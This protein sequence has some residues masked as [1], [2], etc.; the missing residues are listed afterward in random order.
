M[1][2]IALRFSENFSPDGGTIKAHM[3]IIN[4]N[5]YVWYGKMG[6]RIS[7][8]VRREILKDSCDILLIR[9]GHSE[10]YWAKVIE[11]A[12]CPSEKEFVPEYYREEIDLFHTWFKVVSFTEAPKDIMSKCMVSSSKQLLGI[13]SKHSMSPYFVIDYPVE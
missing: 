12:D 11:I 10:R 5:G 8:K 13:V 3:E 6:S 4:K 7:D 9:S 1:K 2:T